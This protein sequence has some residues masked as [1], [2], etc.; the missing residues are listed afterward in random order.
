NIDYDDADREQEQHVVV[1]LRAGERNADDALRPGEGKAADA[2][3]VDQVDALGTVGHVHGRIQIVEE[4]ADDL[5]ETERH[6]R[7][8]VA[9]QLQRR[10]AE[11]YAEDARE[12]GAQGQDHPEWQ[13]KVE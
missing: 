5:A 11:E 8:I 7:E 12:S 2:K 1:L 10:R 3:S 6:D 9:A 13:M 4:D